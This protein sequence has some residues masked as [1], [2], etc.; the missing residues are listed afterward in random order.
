MGGAAGSVALNVCAENRSHKIY[1]WALNE[2]STMIF[3]LQTA[4]REV[5]APC[6]RAP[7]HA[8][9]VGPVAAQSEPRRGRQHITLPLIPSGQNWLEQIVP[10]KPGGGPVRWGA[11]MATM[12]AESVQCRRVTDRYGHASRPVTHRW[13]THGPYERDADL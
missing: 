2:R 10:M 4:T 11:C 1:P 3:P 8:P 5:M 7:V 9:E 6:V 13:E 12:G